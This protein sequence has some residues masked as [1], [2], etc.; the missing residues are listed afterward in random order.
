MDKTS[1]IRQSAIAL[2]VF[3]LLSRLFDFPL[4]NSP[5]AG[6]ALLF[7]FGPW[8]KL[9]W[10][11]AKTQKCQYPFRCL[12]LCFALAVTLVGY[13]LSLILFALGFIP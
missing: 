6:A 12:A 7:V 4:S 9:G 13:V 11:Y 10:H 1:A 5:Q 3:V 2:V 8:W